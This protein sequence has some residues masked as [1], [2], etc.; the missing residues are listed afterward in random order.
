[1]LVFFSSTAIKASL[2]DAKIE[3]ESKEKCRQ[4][5]DRLARQLE[6]QLAALS[7]R[8]G[9]STNQVADL[10]GQRSKMIGE[11]TNLKEQCKEFESVIRYVN[12]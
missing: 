1:M 8:F 2:D 7:V 9:E 11:L 12:T 3:I 4:T 5:N 6:S 10:S